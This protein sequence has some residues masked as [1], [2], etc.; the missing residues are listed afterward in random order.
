MIKKQLKL[1]KKKIL[2]VDDEAD[3]LHS[4]IREFEKDGFEVRVFKYQ[5]EAR[6]YIT[7]GGEY[8]VAII[9]RSLGESHLEAVPITGLELM[10]L[11]KH[12]NPSRAVLSFSGYSDKPL[13]ADRQI[14]KPL[15]IEDIEEL[16]DYI[17]SLPE[18]R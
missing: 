16:E 18:A 13:C 15:L 1:R 17:R 14:I 12:I 11:S 8:D 7:S 10:E 3:K 9:D 2:F 4:L 5:N 6:E